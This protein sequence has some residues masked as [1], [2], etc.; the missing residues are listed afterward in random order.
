[1]IDDWQRTW[2]ALQD[3]LGSKWACHVV[4]ALADQERGF[5]DLERALDGITA[6]ILS[7]RLR[8]LQCRGFVEREVHDTAPLTTTYR[9]TD[10]GHRLATILGDLELLV[11]VVECQDGDC[12]VPPATA[13]DCSSEC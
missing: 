1:M 11:E 2:H 8:E 5:N 3:V 12:A 10:H 4:R 9:L 7:E 13:Q 6:K